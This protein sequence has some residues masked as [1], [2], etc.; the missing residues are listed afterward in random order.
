MRKF[1]FF[2]GV[3]ALLMTSV[4]WV[5][6][7]S[8]EKK[9]GFGGGGQQN[10]IAFLS[11]EDVKKEL[12]VTDDDLA[13]VNT[14]VMA[15]IAKVLNEKQLK[16]FKQLDLQKKAN[17]AFKDD[18]VQKQLKVT[19]EQKTSITTILDESGKELAELFKGGFGKGGGKGGGANFEKI[20]TINKD[21]KEKIYNVLTKEQR[22]AWRDMI[23]DEFK[24]AQQGFGGGGKG[25]KDAPKDK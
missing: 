19:A 25:K 7:F 6:G 12:E 1:G 24:F 9:G 10:P 15:A 13:K 20:G 3:A 4:V 14:E 5:D 2:V 18:G 16:R 22:K 21:A 17:N 11:R 23:G 8:Q